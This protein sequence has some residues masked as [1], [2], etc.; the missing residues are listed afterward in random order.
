[1]L[2]SRPEV[3]PWESAIFPSEATRKLVFVMA[4]RRKFKKCRGVFYFSN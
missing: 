2:I 3:E 1:M 4:E